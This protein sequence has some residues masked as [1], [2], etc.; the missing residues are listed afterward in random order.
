M[1]KIIEI[2]PNYS[3]GKNQ[4]VMEKIVS[5]FRKYKNIS[6][7]TLEMDASYHRSVVT[8]IGEVDSV[9]DAMVDSAILA[10][11][12]IDLRIHKGEHKRMG[13][14]DVCPIIP[15]KNIT[16]AECIE[17]SRVLARKIN[18]ATNIPIFLYAKSATKENRV[19][20]PDIRKGEFEGMAD[21]IKLDEWQPDYGVRKIHPSAGVT[22]VGC[23]L[24][25]IAFNIDLNTKDKEIANQISKRI[26]FSSGGYR[27]IQAGGAYLSDRGHVQ[28]TMN[29]TDFTKTSIYQAFEATKMEA[30]RYNVEATSSEIVGLVAKQALVDSIKYY[31]GLPEDDD[32]DFSLLEVVKYAQ[33][34]LLLR[35]FDEK[36]IIEY[37]V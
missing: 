16:E 9:I 25:L 20:L 11:Q 37:Y 27:F 30:K 18:A 1:E 13:A 12:L 4:D 2:V 10:A 5:P 31:L 14:I 28:V 19:N 3:E 35:D 26:R 32:R 29:I 6:L 34:Y 33:Q 36:K 8:V 17:L 7:V 23:R 21:K 22:A 15:I 24:P